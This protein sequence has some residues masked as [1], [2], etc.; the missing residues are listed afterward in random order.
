MSKA[1]S[2]DD[3]DSPYTAMMEQMLAV[4]AAFYSKNLSSETKRGKRQ[5]AINGE[6]NGSSCPARIRSRQAAAKATP[7]RPAGT[8]YQPASRCPGAS[9]F[10]AFTQ[11]VHTV[12]QIS[13]IG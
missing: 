13:P 5:R 12:M 3:D 8:Q 1:S 9:G 6:F 4:F 10:P 2:E 11:R 7:E